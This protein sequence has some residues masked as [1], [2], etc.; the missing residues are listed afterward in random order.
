MLKRLLF[1][2]L[3]ALIAVPAPALPA[4]VAPPSIER[5]VAHG[6]GD[7]GP[8]LPRLAQ[9]LSDTIPP[10]YMLGGAGLRIWTTNSY[11]LTNGTNTIDATLPSGNVQQLQRTGFAYSGAGRSVVA[12]GGTVTSDANGAAMSGTIYF[13]S[14]GGSAAFINEHIKSFAI[15]NQR[16]PDATLK[17]KSVVGASYAAN[18]NGMRFAF[19]NDNVPMF[20]RLAL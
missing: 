3:A 11:R 4:Q 9:R 8:A 18:D 12:S 14:S 1:L 16:L 13:G 6:A 17:A 7:A 5:P 19:A 20:W 10:L 15:Y 2:V